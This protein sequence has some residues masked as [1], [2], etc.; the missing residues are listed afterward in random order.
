MSQNSVAYQAKLRRR[1]RKR[2]RQTIVFSI[3]IALVLVALVAAIGVYSGQLKLGF[4][5]AE[6][7][8]DQVP[9]DATVIQPCVPS[10]SP[11]VP[12][13]DI[14]VNSLNATD[15]VGLASS[16]SD[17]LSRRGFTIGITGNAPKELKLNNT[18]IAFGEKGL[19]QAYTLLAHLPNAVLYLDSRESADLDLELGLDFQGFTPVGEVKLEAATPMQSVADCQSLSLVP[20]QEHV[21][22]TD[23]DSDD[24]TQQGDDAPEPTEDPAD[25][26]PENEEGATPEGADAGDSE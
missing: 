17:N 11:P 25:A 22:A 3:L 4:L 2:E 21:P 9:T 14:T 15:I 23:A 8:S 18:R 12:Y 1:R 19:L 16:A 5:Q 7:E 10:D 6:F 20:R 13:G 24:S 26:N